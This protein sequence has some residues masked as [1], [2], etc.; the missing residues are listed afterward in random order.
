MTGCKSDKDKDYTKS[1]SEKDEE[2]TKTEKLKTEETS[3]DKSIQI[4]PDSNSCHENF[5]QFFEQFK[6]DSVFQK[7]H[8]KFPLRTSFLSPD[9]QSDELI[10]EFLKE[11]QYQII[12]FSQDEEAWKKELNAYKV[13]WEQQDNKVL[14]QLIGIDNGI[15]ESY[16]FQCKDGDWFLASIENAS[17]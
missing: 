6:N 5:K 1:K 17:T 10:I 14:Y 2:K 13:E 16:E 3:I 15:Y 8:V 7:S 9:P 12:D 4:H 11:N